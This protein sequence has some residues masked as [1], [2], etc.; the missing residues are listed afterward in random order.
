[1]VGTCLRC[2]EILRTPL[3]SNV[4]KT[5]TT[6]EINY[7]LLART[8]Y[9]KSFDGCIFISFTH[10][11]EVL[12]EVPILNV[13]VRLG[14]SLWRHLMKPYWIFPDLMNVKSKEPNPC[15]QHIKLHTVV[16]LLP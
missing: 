4:I 6:S 11:K 1:M 12:F 9:I 5:W 7:A 13:G 3:S 14:C 8:L 10:L 2:T 15:L 16:Y